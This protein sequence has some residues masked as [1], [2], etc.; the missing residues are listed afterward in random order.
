MDEVTFDISVTVEELRAAGSDVSKQMQALLNLGN[1]YLKKAKTTTNG[2]DFTKADAL[3]NA[4]LVRSKLVNHEISGEIL[5]K[6]V[7]TYREFLLSSPNVAVEICAN[8]IRH[9]IDSHKEFL[10]NERRIF[11]ERLDEIDSCF[12][13]TDKTEDEYKVIKNYMFINIWEYKC[14]FMCF[15]NGHYF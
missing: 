3:F 7:E 9:E 6:I 12:N 15:L 2:D 4:A 10:A 13:T 1:C 5:R 11:K 14:N 8:D